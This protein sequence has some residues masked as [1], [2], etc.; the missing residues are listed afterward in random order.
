[1]KRIIAAVLFAQAALASAGQY[2]GAYYCTSVIP[3]MRTTMNGYVA[4]FSH[5]D[6]TAV[7]SL[8]APVATNIYGFGIGTI[9]GTTFSGVSGITGAPFTV[10]FTSS[11]MSSSTL[12]W[13]FG[14]SSYSSTSTC[15]KV[16]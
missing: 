2:D 8:A 4:V 7:L 16:F 5:P 14:S 11:G 12:Q 15:V 1:M 13:T 6:G 10:D 9:S 3:A